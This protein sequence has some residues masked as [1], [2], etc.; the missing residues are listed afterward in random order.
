MTK[1]TAILPAYNEELC[2]SGIILC[3]KKYVDKVIVV[4]DGST[5]N[6]AEIAQLAGAQVICHSSNNGKGAALKTGFEAAKDSDI[7]VTLD[8]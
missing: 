3:S 5:D 6:T 4:D 8:S 7:I 2:I 1:I